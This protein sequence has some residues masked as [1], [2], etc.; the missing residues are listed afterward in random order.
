MTFNLHPLTP[1]VNVKWGK[2]KFNVECNSDESPDVL[3]AQLFCLSGVEPD[4]QKL[5]GKGVSIKDDQWGNTVL[6][7]VI[8][9][10]I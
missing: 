8:I 7:E 4:R 1:I 6:T 5:L 3:K 2:E 10:I 9:C